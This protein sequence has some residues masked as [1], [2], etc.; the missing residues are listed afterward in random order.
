M[1][2]YQT[3][4]LYANQAMKMLPADVTAFLSGAE[5]GLADSPG[6]TLRGLGPGDYDRLLAFR[7]DIVSA[8][9][10]PA[11]TRLM[12]NEEQFVRLSLHED[13]LALGLFR[14]GR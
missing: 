11:L 2:C 14:D 10:N 5:I 12:P 8:I 6:M 7:A 13:H 3:D 9:D 1:S 4:I